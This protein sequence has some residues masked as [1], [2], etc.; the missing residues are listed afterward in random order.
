MDPDQPNKRKDRYGV[1]LILFLHQEG[2]LPQRHCLVGKLPER[3]N[4]PRTR[5]SP[6][7]MSPHPPGPICIPSPH[8]SPC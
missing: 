7:P 6:P 5:G 2:V 4:M 8:P 3:K 1:L